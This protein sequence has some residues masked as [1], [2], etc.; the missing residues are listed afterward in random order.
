VV[1]TA[2]LTLQ[3]WGNSLAVRIPSAVAKSAGLKVGQPVEVSAHDSAVL[4]T[5]VGGPKLTLAQ[6][7]ALF[8]PDRHGGEVMVASRLGNEAL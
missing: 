3:Q 8:D 2:T 5:A 6:K 1:K 4:V 7:L